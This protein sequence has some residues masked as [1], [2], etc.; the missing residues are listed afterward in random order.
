MRYFFALFLAIVSAN[1]QAKEQIKLTDVSGREVTVQVP[2]D[3]LVLGEGR[4]LPTLGILDREDPTKR[5]VGMMGEFKK[6]D[7]STYAQYQ[8]AFPHIDE[9]PLIGSSSGVTFSV[10]KVFS[11]MP[12]VALFG[13]SS[14]HG[15]NDKNKAI[16]DQFTAAGIPVVVID[17]R[18]DPLVNTPKSLKLLGQLMGREKEADAFLD[19]YTTQLN[20]VSDRLKDVKDRPNVF[21][22]SRVGLMPN[23]CE[24]IGKRMMGR[25]IEWAG[26]VNAFGELI[27][28]THGNVNIE[29]LI[30][31]QPDFYI[32][33]AIGSPQTMEHFPKSIALGA[34]TRTAAAR[35]SL[36]ETV[37]RTGIAELRAIQSG[38]AYA[39]WH[40][41]YN[42]PMNVVAVQAIAKWLHPETFTDLEP[43]QTLITYFEKFQSVDLDGV[44]WIGL[45]E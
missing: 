27:P 25:F 43:E 30:T 39:I 9:I 23:C 10:E 29:H 3:R 42:T 20:R 4:F 35:A 34:S 19:F 24:A 17:F 8:K 22:E 32:G 31:E 45:N 7:P 37:K 18:I 2:V 38:H 6:F 26:G 36:R 21:M 12:D 13:L 33:T 1:V 44:Y 28:G 16:L 5:V 40:H 41:F 11:V 15:P 14:G